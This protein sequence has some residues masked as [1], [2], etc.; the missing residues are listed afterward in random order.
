MQNGNDGRNEQH[1]TAGQITG[2]VQQQHIDDDKSGIR[3]LQAI[4]ALVSRACLQSKVRQAY[5]AKQDDG[6]RNNAGQQRGIGKLLE[7]Q[8][9]GNHI[10]IQHIGQRIELFAKCPFRQLMSIKTPGQISIK[11]IEQNS[12]K[13]QQDCPLC[14]V[15]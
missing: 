2:R 3:R 11:V 7:Q 9:G 8:Y 5:A 10:E 13:H 4:S 14:A 6:G 1:Q 12:D 15:G